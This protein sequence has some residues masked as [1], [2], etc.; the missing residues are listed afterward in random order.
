MNKTIKT[1]LII[2]LSIFM[3]SCTNVKAPGTDN[4]DSIETAKENTDPP[5]I[6]RQIKTE[7][8]NVED[9]LS[10]IDL[11]KLTVYTR[12]NEKTDELEVYTIGFDDNRIMTD[13]NIMRNIPLVNIE[14]HEKFIG[15]EVTDERDKEIAKLLGI[16]RALVLNMT[17]N[18]TGK[19]A[20]KNYINKYTKL[21]VMSFS[22]E[23]VIEPNTN[24][25]EYIKKLEENKFEKM[26]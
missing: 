11:S 20:D 10:D 8:A 23:G 26:M 22:Y 4:N 5:N 3:V 21:S 24:V 6:T 13:F 1:T 2:L 12:Y 14:G 9:S 15:Q 17:P 18:L 7:E 16:E 25:D 19:N